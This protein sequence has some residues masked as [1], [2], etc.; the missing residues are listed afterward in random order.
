MGLFEKQALPALRR[1]AARLGACRK[2]LDQ[3]PRTREELCEFYFAYIGFC[4]E[5]DFPTCEYL[6][7][8]FDGLMQQHHIFVEG[9][10]ERR[11]PRRLS[12]GG[13]SRGTWRYDGYGTGWVYARHNARLRVEAAEHAM[14]FV[15]VHDLAQVE[16]VGRS[17]HAVRIFR[18]GGVVRTQGRAEI[19][20]QEEAR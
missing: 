11:N 14:V 3:W 2:A 13:S 1:R 12:A 9:E 19:A 7:R 17:S 15:D 6:K 20:E 16:V 10:F 18:R 5:H 8:H 4:I